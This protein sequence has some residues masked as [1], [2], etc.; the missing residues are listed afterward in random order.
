VGDEVKEAV[1]GVEAA[2]EAA[3]GP[4]TEARQIY[5]PHIELADGMKQR[6][7]DCTELAG[8]EAGLKRG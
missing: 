7:R 2:A 4:A 3:P 1:T 8:S 5:N 6:L